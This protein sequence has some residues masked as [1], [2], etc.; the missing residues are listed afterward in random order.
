[1]SGRAQ[2][3]DRARLVFLVVFDL[4]LVR[5]LV[6]GESVDIRGSRCEK[7]SVS[8]LCEVGSRWLHRN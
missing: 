6:V 5:D 7:M 1:M 2:R 4:Y 8:F 3:A